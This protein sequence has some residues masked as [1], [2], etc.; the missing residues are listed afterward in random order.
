MNT[1]LPSKQMN[2]PLTCFLLLFAT[3]AIAGIGGMSV[4][5][6]RQQ[7]AGSARRLQQMEAETQRLDRLSEELR[8]KIAILESPTAL[9]MVAARLGMQ[10]AKL[11]Q[12]R[13]MGGQATAEKNR[14]A[15]AKTKAP[16]ASK[17]SRNYA[18]DF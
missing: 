12:Y 3:L 9:K 17:D 2:L 1:S 8:A 15:L 7:I 11:D 6:L 13:L 4:V 10:P 18:K 14:S 16:V 5:T